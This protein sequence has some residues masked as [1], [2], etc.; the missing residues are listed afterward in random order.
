MAKEIDKR[1]FEYRVPGLETFSKTVD[2]FTGSQGRI[3]LEGG[4][5]S[6]SLPKYALEVATTVSRSSPMAGFAL[7]FFDAEP[8]FAEFAMPPALGKTSAETDVAHLPQY[9]KGIRIFLVSRTVQ[10]RE[11]RTTVL[12]NS[13]DAFGSVETELHLSANEAVR[14]AGEYLAEG[15][16][17]PS[18]SG[19]GE[20]QVEPLDLSGFDPQTV[21]VF[22]EPMMPTVLEGKPFAGLIK[23]NL[24]YFYQ[25]PVMRLAWSLS[26]LFPEGAAGLFGGR[27]CRETGARRN[28]LRAKPRL[29]SDRQLSAPQPQP[30][31][32]T[33]QGHN[34]ALACR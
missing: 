13:I 11:E 19:W 31:G 23:A 7:E 12:G 22:D 27:R 3:E 34:D 9:Y 16:E 33:R 25:G 32:N 10:V 17:E 30:T 21:A 29:Q 1:D 20:M 18:D 6:K 2:P 15:D 4:S 5:G 8:N 28:P 14:I 26:L 24:T